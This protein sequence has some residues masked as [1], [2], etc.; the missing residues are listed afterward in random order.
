MKAAAIAATISAVLLGGCATLYEAPAAGDTSTVT[1]SAADLPPG[2]YILVQ[3]FENEA[4]DASPNGNRLA[5]FTSTAVQGKGDP[6][7]GTD[8][9]MPAG[10]PA[11]FSFDYTIGAA[12]ITYAESCTVT[13][14][15]V[16]AAGASY[17]A[18]FDFVGR[19]CRVRITRVDGGDPRAVD[20]LRQVTPPCLNGWTG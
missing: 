11:V 2:S 18:H 13:S 1:F 5:T 4:C 15:F 8:R 14:T 7:S 20:D 19:Q 6:R 12:G 10:R 3:N 17:R 9:V 16:P